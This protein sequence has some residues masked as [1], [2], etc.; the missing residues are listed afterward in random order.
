MK[1]TK[2]ICKAKYFKTKKSIIK[3]IKSSEERLNQ[4]LDIYEERIGEVE[5]TYPDQNKGRGRKQE[6]AQRHGE[7]NELF[8][9][10]ECLREEI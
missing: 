2:Q 3:E 1:K 6:K 4:K 8:Q 9:Y 10:K 5:G 7:Q